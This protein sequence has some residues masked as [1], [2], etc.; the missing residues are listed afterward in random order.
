MLK[1]HSFAS[2]HC[3]LAV[4]ERAKDDCDYTAVC[5]ACPSVPCILYIVSLMQFS[6]PV[7]VTS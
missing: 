6:Y 7:E 3:G 1:V 4:A 2:C 5:P